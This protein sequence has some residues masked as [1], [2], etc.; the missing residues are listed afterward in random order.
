MSEDLRFR[1]KQKPKSTQNKREPKKTE[2]SSGSI[3]GIWDE[4]R[5][6]QAEEDKIARELA[7]TKKKAKE[8]SRTLRKHRYGEVKQESLKKIKSIRTN[9]SSKLKNSFYSSKNWS[10]SHKKPVAGIGVFLI[11]IISFLT[12]NRFSSSP[13]DTLG[14]STSNSNSTLEIPSEKPSFS[15]LFPTGSSETDFEV[16]RTNPEGSASTYTYIDSLADSDTKFQITQQEVP[17]NFN[18]EKTAT[19]FQ[20]TNIIQID[21]DRVYHGFS[22][23]TKVQSLIFVKKDRLVL[24][25]SPQKFTDDQW[26]GY[27]ISLQ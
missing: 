15:I 27:I 25:S 8:L 5:R 19:D 23:K 4:Q 16:K 22:E 17:D 7:E 10:K 18:L 6:M 13:S 24:I 12:F 1:F 2:T 20:A 26:A 9:T 21:D 11:L 14:D 3:F